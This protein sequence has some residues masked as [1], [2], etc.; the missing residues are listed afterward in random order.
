LTQVSE[1]LG[2]ACAST[3]LCFGMHCVATAVIAAKATDDQARRYLAPAAA[4]EHFTSL[5]LS[6]PGTGVNLHI[7]RTALIQAPP[8]GFLVRGTKAFVTSGGYADSYVVSTAAAAGDDADLGRFS[9]VMVPVEASG[10]SW[11]EPWA[12]FGMRGNGS[13]TVDLHDVPVPRRDLLGE[14]GDHI[15]YV[16]HAVAPYFLVSMA[17]TYLG[18]AG[19]ALDIA[20][21]HCAA[22]SYDHSGATLGSSA[23]VQHRL[24]TL[25]GALERA[26]QLTYYA[27]RQGDAGADDALVSIL[28]AK[29]EVADAACLIVNEGMTLI[30]GAGYGAKSEMTRLLRDARAAHIMSPTTDL[31]RTWTGR[32]L[33]GRPLLGD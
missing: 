16:F 15:W 23:V 12:G 8:A 9:C 29:A 24:G 2:Q 1:I 18:V 20:R 5:A 28:V 25:H 13:R 4:G 21:A 17:G 6:E 22:R 14:E 32:A 33:L 30:G 31:L 7:P 3:A 27:A 26:R 11:R 19:A 10:L